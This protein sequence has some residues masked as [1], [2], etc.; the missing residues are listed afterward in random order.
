MHTGRMIPAS[1]S[2]RVLMVDP[3]A[4]TPPY[5]RALCEA[6]AAAGADVTLATA[7]FLYE[8][9]DRPRSFSL[10][11]RFFRAAGSWLGVAK[12]PGLRRAL[13]AAEYPLDWLALL[14]DVAR[15]RPDVV[16]VQWS[17][18][19]SLDRLL[20]EATRRLRVPLVYT[21]HNLLPHAAKPGD[22]VRFGQLYRLAD[23]LIVH[24][25]RSAAELRSRWRIPSHR[26]TVAPHGPLFLDVTPMPRD[27]ARRQ[28]GLPPCA[29]LV[30]FA[31]LIEPYKGLTD[32]IAAF[33]D[34]AAR[35]P[36][37][38]LAI[39]GKPNEPMEPYEQQLAAHGLAERAI[40]DL[41]FLPEPELAAYL[42]AADVTVLPYR[43][44]TASG[45]LFAAR[46]FACPV[47]ATATG[48]LAEV[49]TDGESGL[50]APPSD[51]AALASAVERLLTDPALAARLGA[52]GQAAAFGPESWSAA[53]AC[54]LK[55]Y[56]QVLT[57]R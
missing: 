34:I 42:C 28:L 16:H 4:N 36:H 51:P 18:E 54:T 49:I 30:L 26:I 24:S 52:A 23:G 13:K 35:R 20:W 22:A 12:R 50:L 37:A 19:P 1:Q 2:L 47:V 45:M 43:G 53:A 32:L 27:T 55:L 17:F 5:D 14:A 7:P 8:Q 21:V 38:R 11:E 33:A 15:A 57:S 44:T 40:L 10:A 48:D 6:L 39:A 31:G 46:R 41:R 25:E 3:N 29:E 9:L 56:R